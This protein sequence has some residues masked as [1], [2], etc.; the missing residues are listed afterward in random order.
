VAQQ[1]A[2][3][4]AQIDAA[5]A[6]VGSTIAWNDANASGSVSVLRE[7]RSSN[8]QPCREFQQT[9]TIGG[10]SEQAY[11]IACMQPDGAWRIVNTQ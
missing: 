10:R 9:V 1:R 6:P 3:E 5:T 8:G 11:G 2:Q 7:G 4:Q